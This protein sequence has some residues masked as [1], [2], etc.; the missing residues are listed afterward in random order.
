[1]MIV[2]LLL[3]LVAFPINVMAH[4]QDNTGLQIHSLTEAAIAKD[5]GWIPSTE[6]RCGGNYLEQP[7]DSAKELEHSDLINVKANQMLFAQHGTSIGEGGVTITRFGQQIVASKAYLYR[8]PVTGKLSTIDLIDN[9][10]LREPNNLVIAKY[11]HFDLKTKGESLHDILYRTSIYSTHE[12][13]KNQ[14]YTGAE[15]EKVRKII[16]LTAWGRA[17][18]FKQSEPQIYDLQKVSYSTCPPTSN[19]WQV[20]ASDINLNKVTGRGVA[21]NAR[22]YV[23]G[24][25]I[26]YTPYL[27]F[28][29][30]ARRQTGFLTS[31]IGHS[32]KSGYAVHTPFYWNMAPNYDSTL[33]PAYMS[34]R[35]I[36]LSELFRYLT[37]TSTGNI[38]VAA[39]PSDQAFMQQKDSYPLKYSGSTDPFVLA[40]LQR[41]Q[42]ASDSRKSLFWKDDS[43]FNEHWF[44]NVDYS[45]VSDDYYLSDLRN[46]FNEVTQNQLLQQGQIGYESEHWKVLT[47]LQGYETLHPVDQSPVL[48][49]YTRLP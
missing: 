2:L 6:N 15:L 1:M 37:P 13:Q 47:R 36:Q 40:D 42:N 14:V 33:T 21:R 23:K 31:T 48:N 41:L 43:R 8:D 19:T 26:F 11:A 24:V 35:G 9:V 34:K 27:N 38:Y 20:Q 28:P 18:E 32:S 45:Y 25:P 49:Q 7:F 17:Y 30:D 39:L 29:L 46:N 4:T 22:L 44:A 12:A 16:Q 3:A 5:L 10:V